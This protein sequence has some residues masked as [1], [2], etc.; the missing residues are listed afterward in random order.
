M[1]GDKVA[2][3]NNTRTRRLDI[4]DRHYTLLGDP[5]KSD[6]KTLDGAFVRAGA[7]PGEDVACKFIRF[8]RDGQFVD[9]GIVTI[10]TPTDISMGNSRFERAAGS[11]AWRLGPYTLILRYADGYQRQLPIIIEPADM[12]KPVLSKLIVNT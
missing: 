5:A 4:A 3:A 1:N 2:F 6:A 12:E 10:V 8:T 11:G 9:Q 7:Q